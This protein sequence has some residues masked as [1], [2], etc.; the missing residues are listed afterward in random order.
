MNMNRLDRLDDD[1][2]EEESSRLDRD[3]V[4]TEDD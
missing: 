3:S 2:V 4:G 1:D